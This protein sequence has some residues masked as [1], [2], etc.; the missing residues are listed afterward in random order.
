MFISFVTSAQTDNQP[1][2]PSLSFDSCL[3]L[4][5]DSVDGELGNDLMFTGDGDIN[6]YSDSIVLT[7]SNKWSCG[8]YLIHVRNVEEY[9]ESDRYIKL[10][11]GKAEYFGWDCGV[12]L[13]EYFDGTVGVLLDNNYKEG[14][15]M[16]RR[17][18]MNL[19]NNNL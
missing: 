5:R 4:S 14:I 9:T 15:A 3:V 1:Y 6:F 2:L 10:Y 18:Y 12:W 8:K 7:Y 16:K 13:I 19:K 17:I 11:T